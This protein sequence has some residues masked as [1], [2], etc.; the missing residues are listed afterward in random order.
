MLARVAL[1]P[2]LALASHRPSSARSAKSTSDDAIA[3]WGPFAP[4]LEPLS[5]RPP[6]LVHFAARAA[7]AARAASAQTVEISFDF[8]K[9][10]PTL[11][12]VT[13]RGLECAWLSRAVFAPWSVVESVAEDERGVFEPDPALAEWNSGRWSKIVSFSEDTSRAVSL[14]PSGARTW[15]TAL[16]A[17]FSMHRFGIDVD[18]REDT[19]KK[20]GAVAPIRPGARVLDIC[21]GLAYTCSMAAERGARVTT[22]ELDSTMTKMCRMNP[23][24]E[25]L[26]SGNIEQ[27]Y[28]N[29]ADVVKTFADAEFD[30]IITDPPTFALAGELYS[31]EFYAELKR[32]LKPKGKLYHYI[33][34]PKSSSGS[35]VA[36][37]VVRRLKLAGFGGVEIDYDAHGI[38][39]AH[40]HIKVNRSSSRGALRA[41]D[42]LR[43]DKHFRGAAKSGRGRAMRD[44]RADRDD[45]VDDFHR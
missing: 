40:D 4:P 9:T 7:L 38:I 3:P 28:G 19:A 6:L 42:R 10:A 20:L 37:G 18:P 34:D 24:S 43:A 45:V 27:L 25:A 8:Y 32:V 44:A 36:A 2:P 13:E 35:T 30:R 33:G 31:S 5:P 26:F 17:G 22:I 23:H 11:A 29:G 15:P 14:M 21:T 1:S 12:S 16:V 41:D 39:A